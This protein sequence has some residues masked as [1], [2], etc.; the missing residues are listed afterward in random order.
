MQ[1]PAT[2]SWRDWIV[3]IEEDAMTLRQ[4]LDVSAHLKA[5]LEVPLLRAYYQIE[6]KRY[7]AD[8][9]SRRLVGYAPAG[10]SVQ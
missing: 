9:A 8:R 2:P 5:G 3:P 10:N 6:A 4:A 1:N 7:P